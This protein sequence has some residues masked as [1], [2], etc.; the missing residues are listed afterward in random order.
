MLQTSFS[1]LLLSESTKESRQ[2]SKVKAL[3]SHQTAKNEKHNT[4]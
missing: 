1:K 3:D 2:N 4:K